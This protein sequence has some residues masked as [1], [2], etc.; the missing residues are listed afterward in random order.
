MQKKLGL[1]LTF[2]FFVMSC[3]AL[4]AQQA[5]EATHHP[6]KVLVI[7]REWMKPGK[8]G[9]QH[10]RTESMFPAAFTAAK[11]PQHYIGMDSLS[12]APRSLFLVGYDTFEAWEK[13]TMDTQK[14]AVLSAALD[15]ASAA[16]ADMLSGSETNVLVYRPDMSQNA[17]VDIPHMRY[18]ELSLFK[19]KA[20]H[21]AEWKELVKTY[22]DG[23]KDMPDAHWAV[24]Q[25]QYGQLGGGIYL[26]VTPMKST[27]EV[28]KSFGDMKKF[29][30]TLGE[31]GMKKLSA[32]AGS[33]IESTQTN[34]FAF[35]PRTSYVED[36][37]KKADAFWQTSPAK[38]AVIAKKTDM[39]PKP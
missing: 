8:A 3:V 26:V 13:D 17:G 16:D 9:A 10:E 33:C 22:Q 19:V 30:D 24:Y 31:D 21:E 29:S 18:F 28:D 39:K 6:P 32:L 1:W 37:W 25:S 4:E 7:I 5:M 15:K 11:W 14:N 12:G 34:L 38:A 23:Y 27:A 36:G 20:G 35:N 2:A